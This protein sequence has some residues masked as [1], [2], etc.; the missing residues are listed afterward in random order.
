[1]TASDPAIPA[2]S[3]DGPA[4]PSDPDDLHVM[5]FNLRRP[6]NRILQR[7]ADRWS[8]RAPAVSA[9]LRASRPAVLA[10]QEALPHAMPTVR[11]A[12]GDAY[13]SLGRGR[14]PEGR[15]EGTPLLYDSTR[16]T[17][18]AWRQEAVSDE[19][20]RAGSR[21]RGT[22]FPRILV[23][24]EFEDRRT[25]LVFLAVNTHLDPLSV[26]SRDRSVDRIHSL[27][28][29]RA[30]PT[31][32]LGD[33]NAGPRSNT[34]RRMLH[35]GLLVD[36]WT[37]AQT[38]RSPEWGTHAN[39]RPPRIGARRIDGIL[40]TPDIDVR[41]TAVDARRF[42]GVFPSDHLPVHAILRIGGAA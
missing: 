22:P 7:R 14:G 8:T 28:G 17:V 9:L 13:R 25:G 33:F 35:D 11:T 26:R 41:S 15:G 10:L 6:T 36:A 38:R 40:T 21:D 42:F 31:I 19:P 18:R 3:S 32:V 39:Y 20:D 5:T 4:G 37:A 29:A 1:M 27:I 23:W 30:L 2:R 34:L 16:L 24:A 12:L